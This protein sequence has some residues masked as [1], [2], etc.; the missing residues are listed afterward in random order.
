MMNLV[1][2]KCY[3]VNH[4]GKQG[5]YVEMHGYLSQEQLD[6]LREFIANG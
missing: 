2:E 1:F 5:M 3:H 6:K 4:Q